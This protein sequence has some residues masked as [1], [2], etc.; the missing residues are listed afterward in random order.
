MAEPL[1]NVYNKSFFETFTNLLNDVIPDFNEA[2][3]LKG[4]FDEEWESRELK[5]RMYHISDVLHDHLPADFKRSA[6]LIT[7]LAKKLRTGEEQTSFE[8]MFLPDYIEKHGLN[9]Y[10]TSMAAF[11]EITQFTSCEFAVRPFLVRYPAQMTKQMV[12]WS[13][14]K[15]STVRRLASEGCRP[16]LPWAMALPALKE[17]PE[18]ILEILENLKD[19]VSE[20][21]RRSVANNLNDISKDN[22]DIVVGIAKSWHGKTEVTDAL[23]KHACRTLLKQGNSEM[24]KLFGLGSSEQVDILDFAIK[25][26][27]VRVG[28][29]LTFTFSLHNKRKTEAKIR[30]EYGLYYQKANGSLSK[31]VFKISEKIYPANSTTKIVRNQPFKVI[32]T[33][34][35]HPGLHKVSLIVNGA[36]GEKYDFELVD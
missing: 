11:E 17:N 30:L 34:K 5:Q 21:V 22:P 27:Q 33:R 15:E 25:T 32:T 26:P 35:F 7:R 4:I 12:R 18:P 1:K 20:F 13:L 6:E 23:V 29:E 14:H 2:L 31:K 3:F 9:N 10:K 36:E 8:Y 19:D 28:E 24:M 16:R